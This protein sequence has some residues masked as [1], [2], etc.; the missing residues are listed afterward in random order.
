MIGKGVRSLLT[1]K[2]TS[3][4]SL[5]ESTTPFKRS[6]IG[7]NSR[8]RL[9]NIISSREKAEEIIEEGREITPEIIEQ[10][11]PV[12]ENTKEALYA[13]IELLENKEADLL[14]VVTA[15]PL[16]HD[17]KDELELYKEILPGN[18]SITE[19]IDS[20]D[21]SARRIQETLTN[22]TLEDIKRS[23]STLASTY[24][25]NSTQNKI[26]LQSE[27]FKQYIK[28]NYIRMK[29]VIAQETGKIIN[30]FD[31]EISHFIESEFERILNM[32]KEEVLL[33]MTEHESFIQN[34]QATVDAQVALFDYDSDSIKTAVSIISVLNKKRIALEFYRQVLP[35]N[36]LTHSTVDTIMDDID[37][38]TG[39][40]EGFLGAITYQDIKTLI[41]DLAED[42]LNNVLQ[43]ASQIEDK[44][45]RLFIEE[46]YAQIKGIIQEEAGND[47]SEFDEE[48]PQLLNFELEKIKEEW[49]N[50][51]PLTTKQVEEPVIPASPTVTNKE[52]EW[53]TTIRESEQPSVPITA[54]QE[55]A[56]RKKFE[57]I[58][59]ES[60]GK[61]EQPQEEF[62][63]TKTPQISDVMERPISRPEISIQPN[64]PLANELQSTENRKD[65]LISDIKNTL[66]IVR[67]TYLEPAIEYTKTL[68]PDPEAGR[69]PLMIDSD[70]IDTISREIKDIISYLDALKGFVSQNPEIFLTTDESLKI[71]L[72]SPFNEFLLGISTKINSSGAVVF[73]KRMPDESNFSLRQY[74]NTYEKYFT[75]NILNPED[76]QENQDLLIVQ[77]N[78]L[79]Q[80]IDT[81]GFD[82]DFYYSYLLAENIE[83]D[84]ILRPIDDIINILQRKQSVATTEKETFQPEEQIFTPVTTLPPVLSEQSTTNKMINMFLDVMPK[85]ISRFISKSTAPTQTLRDLPPKIPMERSESKIPYPDQ[86]ETQTSKKTIPDVTSTRRQSPQEAPNLNIQ[87]QTTTAPSLLERYMESTQ[88]RPKIFRAPDK[89]QR[90]RSE[91]LQAAWE[92]IVDATKDPISQGLQEEAQVSTTTPSPQEAVGS[93]RQEQTAVKESPLEKYMKSTQARTK[94]FKAPAK[95]RSFKNTSL[96]ATSQEFADILERA[97]EETLTIEKNMNRMPDLTRT[98]SENLNKRIDDL[99]KIVQSTE[100]TTVLIN[101]ELTREEFPAMQTEETLLER[102]NDQI[103]T[104]KDIES[105]TMSPLPP[106]Y[107]TESTVKQNP[108]LAAASKARSDIAKS[109]KKTTSTVQNAPK[110]PIQRK[111]APTTQEKPSPPTRER[112]PT[113]PSSTATPQVSRPQPKT[114]RHYDNGASYSGGQP[115]FSPDSR[116]DYDNEEYIN[117]YYNEDYN[118]DRYF[119]NRERAPIQI[120]KEPTRQS[121][122]KDLEQEIR[123]EITQEKA[124]VETTDK[125]TVIPRRRDVFIT[126]KPEPISPPK[127]DERTVEQSS[128]TELPTLLN[129]TLE[130]LKR[131]IQ[132][133]QTLF[134]YNK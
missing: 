134:S 5:P 114:T 46:N 24:L 120:A 74:I 110:I 2:S 21:K 87:E 57:D 23:I 125:Q 101:E 61:K 37:I 75:R 55:V 65:Q 59:I 112:Q 12:V 109:R 40:I 30:E 124:E 18:S 35:E 1:K 53:P 41:S 90:F 123:K 111:A 28:E 80:A 70:S 36:F 17:K 68:I 126:P 115:Y 44:G 64:L 119:T 85:K 60:L 54:P 130:F 13:Q 38:T 102:I 122:Q 49:E 52:T 39:T 96:Q 83:S 19:A 113:K 104:I 79:K 127:R 73:S 56:P 116:Y 91:D 105:N 99:K 43:S 69:L 89:E 100:K 33:A 82:P 50:I 15:V 26:P 71:Q 78:A 76:T 92:K 51:Q 45:F 63:I 20:I 118:N 84:Y 62:E 94:F 34:I 14:T 132:K 48:I 66:T 117:R 108:T 81:V 67:D 129:R 98:E 58:S 10:Y 42:Y 103:M 131:M 22:I 88:P 25:I 86:A 121:A 4:P 77:L 31:G 6:K 11:E 107:I 47:I 128:P 97:K 3:K 9:K 8:E 133:V 93:N 95:R 72:N 16:L 29:E 27:I 32:A 106:E 7:K